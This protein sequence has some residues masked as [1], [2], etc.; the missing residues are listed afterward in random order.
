MK[1]TFA[2]LS[3]AVVAAFLVV[4]TA[5]PALAAPAQEQGQGQVVVFENEITPLTT[6]NNPNGC[7]KLPL[8]AH[9]LVNQTDKPVRVYADPLC[10]SPSLTISPGY[11]SHVAPLSGS[12]SV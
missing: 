2:A 12:F 4:A 11:G 8:L 7:Y 5:T 1:R 6:Y 10:L 3:G 9:V